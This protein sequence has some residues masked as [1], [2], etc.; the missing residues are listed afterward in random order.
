MPCLVQCSR[1]RFATSALAQPPLTDQQIAAIIVKASRDA[2]YQTGH[3]CAC[4]EDLARNGSRCGKRSRRSISALHAEAIAVFWR[5]VIF[6]V[7]SQDA[8]NRP[9]QRRIFVITTHCDSGARYKTRRSPPALFSLARRMFA[10]AASTPPAGHGQGNV[11]AS[12]WS[13]V[14]PAPRCNAPPTTKADGPTAA[15][16]SPCRPAGIGV[17][18]NQ[19]PVFGS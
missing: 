1:S 9:L 4:L 3:P 14:S 13:V 19:R 17:S 7:R 12:S 5:G 10:W 6:L 2:Y 18:F 11:K 15:T 16:P 8:R